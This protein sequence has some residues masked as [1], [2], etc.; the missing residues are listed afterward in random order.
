MPRRT[1]NK[2]MPVPKTLSSAAAPP[3]AA[4]PKPMPAP[5]QQGPSITDSIKQGFSFGIGSAIAHNMVNRV[6]GK[7]E[8]A[9]PTTPLPTTPITTPQQ[10]KMYELYYQCM[11]KNDKNVNCSDILKTDLLKTDLLN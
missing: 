2:P 1:N 5:L 4:A 10:D 6:F 8:S 9:L 11:E 3:P 7:P